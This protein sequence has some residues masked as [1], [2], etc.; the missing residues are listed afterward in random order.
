MKLL[1]FEV[2]FETFLAFLDKTNLQIYKDLSQI[3]KTSFTRK[4]RLLILGLAKLATKI[5]AEITRSW[6]FKIY[7]IFLTACSA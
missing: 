5:R 1:A 3:F 7:R 6:N 4:S 2:K